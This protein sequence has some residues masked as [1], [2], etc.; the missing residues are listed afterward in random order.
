MVSKESLTVIVPALKKSVAFQDD[1]VKKLAGITLVQRAIDKAR[2]LG[3]ADRDIHLMT[4]SEEIGLIAERN[5]VGVYFDQGLRWDAGQINNKLY[6][7]LRKS[8]KDNEFVLVLSPYAPLLEVELLHHAIAALKESKESFLIPVKVEERRLIE[9]NTKGTLETIF[10]DDR[11]SH[12]IE[13]KA[14]NLMRSDIFIK[15]GRLD[16]GLLVWQVEHDLIEIESFQDWWVC[17]KLLQRKRIL[18]RII[19][20]E[21]LGMGH[22]YRA[23]SLAHDIT[24]HE[25]LFVCDKEHS[26]AVNKLAG[27]EYWLGIYDHDEL[28]DKIIELKPDL[29]VNDIL[30]TSLDDVEPLLE[31][32]IRVVNFEDLGEGA[33][34]ADLTFNELYDSPQIEGDNIHWGSD[35]FFV[36]DEFHH[37]SPHRFKKK[38]DNILLTFGGTDQHDLSRRIYQTIA[39]ICRERAV[40]INIVTGSAYPYYERLKKEVSKDENVFLTHATG[41]MSGVMEQSQVAISSNGRT[42]YE[43]AHMN[44]PA[45]VVS[46]HEREDTHRFSC[47]ENGFIPVGV[48]QEGVTEQQVLALIRRLFDDEDF[49]HGLFKSTLKFKFTRTKQL[50]LNKMFSLLEERV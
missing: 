30:S 36:R 22:I 29:V 9:G 35:Y 48:Y 2:E 25:I 41:V 50:V 15:N 17:E 20:S 45:V 31:H 16:E 32:D 18:F 38:V 44:I 34:L 1:L 37:A 21:K 7:Y 39:P 4:D 26:V 23:L 27:Y 33:G 19:G 10:G 6:R 3:V 47:R 14:F 24:D 13:S 40:K 42:V 8:T 12:Q 46:Q 5:S 28:I 43:L 49:R 11:E